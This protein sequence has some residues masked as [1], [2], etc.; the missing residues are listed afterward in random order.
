MLPEDTK[1]CEYLAEEA[2]FFTNQVYREARRVVMQ[3]YSLG[4]W[5]LVDMGE[6]MHHFLHDI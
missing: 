5:Q 3:D 4:R 1:K 6:Q 2:S